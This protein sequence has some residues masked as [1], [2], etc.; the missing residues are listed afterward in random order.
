MSRHYGN[1]Y[2]A[3]ITSAPN[4][5]ATSITPTS[6]T[7]APATPF[8]ARIRNATLTADGLH[9]TKEEIVS[10]TNITIGVCTI[11]RASEAIWN[12]TQSAVDFTGGPAVLEHPVTGGGIAEIDAAPTVRHAAGVPSGAP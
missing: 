5:S 10:V 12:G 2:A 9:F 1:G 3:A 6:V 7:G 11:T 8:D 4:G